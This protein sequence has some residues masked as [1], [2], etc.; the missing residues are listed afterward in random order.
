MGMQVMHNLDSSIVVCNKNQLQSPVPKMLFNLFNT[1]FTAVEFNVNTSQEH[2]RITECLKELLPTLQ[3]ALRQQFT[4]ESKLDFVVYDLIDYGAKNNIPA[5]FSNEHCLLG[6]VTW[7]TMGTVANFKV[8]MSL[9][10]ASYR[11]VGTNG[12]PDSI[13]IH[14]TFID[15]VFEYTI[16]FIVQLLSSA[17][18]GN[19][20]VWNQWFWTGCEIDTQNKH[21][22]VPDIGTEAD[23]SGKTS[24]FRMN[25]DVKK[26]QASK[27][28][29]VLGSSKESNTIVSSAMNEAPNLTL[30]S[31]TPKWA[32][33]AV[34]LFQHEKVSVE[35]LC[36][37]EKWIA[38]EVQE[39]CW[40]DGGKLSAVDLPNLLQTGLTMCEQKDF[41]CRLSRVVPTQ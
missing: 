1:T 35:F 20:E 32:F 24:V 41:N 9:H 27:G 40:D 4:D 11:A 15:S 22:G 33:S 39:N 3:R 12:L 5:L 18:A 14:D 2:A 28:S 34:K 25:T 8:C 23:S 29:Q 36:L 21:S 7:V 10:P 6:A 31:N 17:S 13:F 26:S 19:W 38:F 37:V 30:P 16:D